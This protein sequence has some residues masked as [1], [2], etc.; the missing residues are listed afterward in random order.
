MSKA[1]D[2]ILWGVDDVM[3][4]KDVNLAESVHILHE[5]SDIIS[6]TLRL[7]PQMNYCHTVDK[8]T[9]VPPGLLRLL[10]CFTLNRHRN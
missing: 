8:V 5:N 4:F 9:V 1:D 7:T 10:P 3:Y 6:S 2:Y